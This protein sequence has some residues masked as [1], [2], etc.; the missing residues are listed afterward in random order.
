MVGGPHGAVLLQGLC[1]YLAQ[2]SGEPVELASLAPDVHAYLR[3]VD[4]F[5]QA[6]GVARTT[7]PFDAGGD[8]ARSRRVAWLDLLSYLSG[9]V[10]G[11]T[12]GEWELFMRHARATI[13][14][15]DLP[16]QESEEILSFFTSLM[17]EV[18]EAPSRR[19]SVLISWCRVYAAPAKD[20]DGS[21][22]A[23]VTDFWLDTPAMA[24]RS[25]TL[26]VPDHSALDNP[27]PA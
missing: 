13:E 9:P 11:F 22:G 12:E 5:E 18:V 6:K 25:S 15:F 20:D 2:R 19:R 1:R 7:M 17:R 23:Y 21:V 10:L 26:R 27:T 3:R 8:Y 14:K 24:R 4:F 16:P